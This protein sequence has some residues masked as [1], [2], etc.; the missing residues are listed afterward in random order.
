MA[1][2]LLPKTNFYIVVHPK[3]PGHGCNNPRDW[4]DRCEDMEAQIRRHIDYVESVEIKS[5]TPR[6][7][8]HCGY[9][10]TEVSTEYNGGCCK[11]DEEGNP[12]HSAQTVL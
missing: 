3:N 11:K 12:L 2:K 4:Q 7:C 8:E 9:N 5:T 1:M 10:W 6:V